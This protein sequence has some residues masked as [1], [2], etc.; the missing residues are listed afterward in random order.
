MRNTNRVA[1]AYVL[2][3]AVRLY[4]RQHRFGRFPF[5]PRGNATGF[6]VLAKVIDKRTLWAIE[7][8]VVSFL[9]NAVPYLD[10]SCGFAHG[11][12]RRYAYRW[13]KRAA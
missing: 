11:R 3:C 5:A 4:I 12:T 13:R 2:A 9:G 10:R 7:L 6:V 1:F 8:A